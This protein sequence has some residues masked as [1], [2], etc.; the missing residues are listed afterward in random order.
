MLG[1]ELTRVGAGLGVVVDDGL[2]DADGGGER[3]GGGH[4]RVGAAAFLDE[5]HLLAD[6]GFGE[7]HGEDVDGD[8]EVARDGAEGG[9]GV[10]ERGEDGAVEVGG[11]EGGVGGGGLGSECRGTRRKRFTTEGHGGP[12]RKR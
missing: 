2:Q 7:P 8:A 3:D 10:A 9:A 5:E 1:S 4:A 6:L 12:R 11:D